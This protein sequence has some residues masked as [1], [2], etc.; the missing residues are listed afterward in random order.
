MTENNT[1]ATA[2]NKTTD[3]LTGEAKETQ[4]KI[5]PVKEKVKKNTAEKAAGTL[6]SKIARIQ[7]KVKEVVKDAENKYQ[8]YF[9]FTEAAAI[10]ELKPLMDAEGVAQT[11]SDSQDLQHFIYEQRDKEHFI[12]YLKII[13]ISDG[14]ETLTFYNWAMAQDTDISKT[15]GKAETYANKYFLNKFWMIPI[16]DAD[17]P[18]STGQAAQQQRTTTSQPV[19]TGATAS[20]PI[21][22]TWQKPT[23]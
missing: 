20:N 9:Y 3:L 5:N 16:A 11:T 21:K 4:A 2:E 10:K 7:G 13:T 19:R 14:V 1:E 12:R 8:K 18:D 22:Q 15:K 6:Y 17:D 23:N